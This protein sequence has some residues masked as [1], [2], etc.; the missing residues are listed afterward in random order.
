MT[1]DWRPVTT[2]EWVQAEAKKGRVKAAGGTR[3]PLPSFRL[4]RTTAFTW[5]SSPVTLAWDAAEADGKLEGWTVANGVFSCTRP[6]VWRFDARVGISNVAATFANTRWIYNGQAH[7]GY[8][9]A[10]ST[11][12]FT[13]HGA[14]IERR[15]NV[16]DTLALAISCGTNGTAGVLKDG[17]AQLTWLGVRMLSL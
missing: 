9:G 8:G 12:A 16:G 3:R 1:N 5:T 11:A 6:G 4:W 17:G 15:F 13:S 10:T 14:P 7:E 2:G